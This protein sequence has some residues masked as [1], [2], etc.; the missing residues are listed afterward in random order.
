MKAL[1]KYI[2]VI[3]ER[4]GQVNG[5]GIAL[6]HQSIILGVKKETAPARCGCGAYL[7]YICNPRTQP[8]PRVGYKKSFSVDR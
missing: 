4:Q 1:T 2:C 8:I 6:V 3:F 5:L 7:N